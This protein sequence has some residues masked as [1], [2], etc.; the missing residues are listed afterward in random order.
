MT[1]PACHQDDVSV[2]LPPD[3]PR[4]CVSGCIK[5]W[6][7]TTARASPERCVYMFVQNPNFKN[8][9]QKGPE[10][11][12]AKFYTKLSRGADCRFARRL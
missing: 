3:A 2:R 5:G 12:T 11:K 10:V 1:L 4:V 8:L 9:P 7:V 6:S